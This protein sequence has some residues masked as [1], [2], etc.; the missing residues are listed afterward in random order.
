M[1]KI[2]YYTAGICLLLA[3][4]FSSAGAGEPVTREEMDELKKEMQEMKALVG[5]LKDIIQQQQGVI[6]DL[7]EEVHEAEEVITDLK[8]DIHEGEMVAS[9]DDEDEDAHGDDEDG[10][11]FEDL[12]GEI[13]PNISITG[14]FLANV[15]DETNTGHDTDRFDLRGVDLTF[16]GEI[17]EKG[18]A[19]F[20]LA[21][22]DDD[23]SL[24]EGYLDVWNILPYETDLKV[25]RFRVNFGLLNTIHPHALQQ[26][27][28]PAIYREYLGHEGYIDEGLGVSG[29]FASPWENPF[30]WSLQVVSGNRHEHAGEDH[31]DDDDEDHDEGNYKKLKDFDDTPVIAR[32]THRF[33]PS[34]TLSINWGLSGLSGKLEDDGDSPRY[35][36]EGADLTVNWSPFENEHKRIRWQTETFFSQIDGG[37]YDGSAFGYYSFL[38]YRFVENWLAGVRYD[39]AQ[40]P[41]DNDEHLREYSAYLTHQY[42]PNNQLRLQIKESQPDYASNATE[43]WLQWVF[44]LGR[45]EHLE[46]EDH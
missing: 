21:Y 10:H 14:D 2:A 24:E 45:H 8:K 42:T 26:V 44:T 18:R 32:L 29:E 43:V 9:H 33:T 5:D 12:L 28:Y 13:K 15:G 31:D 20:N 4:S 22:H 17:D 40:L 38:D 19:V 3:V 39:Y 6:T 36:L 35:Y 34:D 46:G 1:K 27:D 37:E 23:V 30:G 41:M 16:M 7:K 11:I 25:G